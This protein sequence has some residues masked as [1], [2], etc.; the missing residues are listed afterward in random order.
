M[1]YHYRCGDCGSRQTLR[2][3]LSEYVR[4][5]RCKWCG[6]KRLWADRYRDKKELKATC[7]CDGYH[8]PHRPNSGVW[9]RRHKTGP[10]EK[11]LAE[12]YGYEQAG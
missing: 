10:S 6:S 3:H 8:F 5:K 1:R 7:W 11:Q 4:T 2:K 9:C 12:R